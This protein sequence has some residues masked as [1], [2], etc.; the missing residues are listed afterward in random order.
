[1]ADTE[2]RTPPPPL[3]AQPAPAPSNPGSTANNDNTLAAVSYILL[4]ITGLIVLL[5]SKPYE[6]Y[7][8]WHAL[9]AIGL[10]IVVTVL[11][12]LL[13]IL[14][15]IFAPTA[16]FGLYSTLGGLISLLTIVLIIILAIKAYQGEKVRLPVIA[17]YADKNA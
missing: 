4:W 11:Q 15:S 7:K 6:K 13:N 2:T 3:A 10:G 16:G 14:A 1:M 17:D 8:R 12:I 9:Q 5:T